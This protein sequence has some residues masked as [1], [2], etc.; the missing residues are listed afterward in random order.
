VW[1]EC[2]RRRELSSAAEA[3]ESLTVDDSRVRA[4]ARVLH[5]DRS[6]SFVRTTRSKCDEVAHIPRESWARSRRDRTGDVSWRAGAEH[7]N[8]GNL[9]Y[10]VRASLTSRMSGSAFFHSVKRSSYALFA[11]VVSPE[12]A[13]ARASCSRAIASMGS[14]R[15]MLR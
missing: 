13:S 2:Q 1:P 11:F 15:T 6:G 14:T 9:P 10:S 8:H 5:Q 12:S 3:I 4:G 7:V